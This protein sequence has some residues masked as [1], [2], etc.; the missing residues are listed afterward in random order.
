M[1]G[2][3]PYPIK[4]RF[5]RRSAA[6]AVPLAL[7][8]YFALTAAAPASAVG[9]RPALAAVSG[10]VLNAQAVHQG[11]ITP[12]AATAPNVTILPNV[13]ISNNGNQPAN[14]VPITANPN[15]AM[16]LESGANDYN[17][18][19]VQ[20]FYNSDDGVRPGRTSTA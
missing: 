20:G 4:Y 17:C 19:S 18:D 1:A 12:R 5:W 13:K 14:E 2:T 10:G 6:A 11:R 3:T 8:A 9:S 16:Q 7:A 15:N